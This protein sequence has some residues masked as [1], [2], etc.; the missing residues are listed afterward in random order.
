M[1]NPNRYKVEAF[2]DPEAEVWVAHSED[3]LGLATE[4]ATLEGLTLRLK[5][6]IPELLAANHVIP[7]NTR[8]NITFELT[9]RRAEYISVP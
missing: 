1:V 4:S 5:Q 9:T 3:I 8:Q 2:W 7:P 6:I